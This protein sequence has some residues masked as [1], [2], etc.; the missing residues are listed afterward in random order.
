MYSIY[1]NV[2]LSIRSK[3]GTL[4]VTIFTYISTYA[5]PKIAAVFSNQKSGWEST[6]TVCGSLSLLHLLLSQSTPADDRIHI[7]LKIATVH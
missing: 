5:S 1:Q 3:T 7:P 2:Q 6:S 4:N